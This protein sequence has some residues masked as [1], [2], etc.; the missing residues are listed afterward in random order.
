MRCILERLID[1]RHHFGNHI[2]VPT[3]ERFAPKPS[4]QTLSRSQLCNPFTLPAASR[5]C[6]MG[7]VEAGEGDYLPGGEVV[8]GYWHA[9][10]SRVMRQGLGVVVGRNTPGL[11]NVLVVG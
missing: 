3:K 5:H 7:E 11:I 8:G 6:K 1:S 4:L 9:W 10:P 2:G